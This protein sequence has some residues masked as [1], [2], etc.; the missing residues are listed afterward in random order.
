VLQF[1]SE[2]CF[3]DGTYKVVWRNDPIVGAKLVRR[4]SS[5]L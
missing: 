3:K 2:G 4:R 1:S 5:L